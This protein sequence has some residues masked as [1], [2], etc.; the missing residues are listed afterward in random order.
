MLS[1]LLREITGRVDEDLPPYVIKNMS[2]DVDEYRAS[3]SAAGM[4]YVDQS[5]HLQP[6]LDALSTSAQRAIRKSARKASVVGAAGG[7]AGF[8]GVPPE[9]AARLIQSVR[10]AQRL[11]IIYGHD[12]RTDRGSMHVRRALAAGWDFQLPAQAK[13]DMRLSDLGNVVRMNLP[14]SQH[15]GEWLARTLLNK[16]TT[17]VSSRIGRFVPGLG[18]GLGALQAHRN[19]RIM[20]KRMHSTYLR[21]YRHPRPTGVEDAVEV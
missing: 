21:S 3:L 16:A 11:A 15:S 6:S 10:L 4:E 14:A 9:A 17:S 2:V 1:S 13:V 19:A 7:V 5:M 20:G 8:L 12:P 18:A